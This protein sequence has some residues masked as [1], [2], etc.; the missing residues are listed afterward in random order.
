LT[1][2]RLP[3]FVSSRR[4][5]ALFSSAVAVKV[6]I[7]TLTPMSLE[8]SL[9]LSGSNRPYLNY[10]IYTHESRWG[11][12]PYGKLIQLL[13]AAWQAMPLQHPALSSAWSVNFFQPSPA[14]YL[15][16][17]LLKLP[18]LL[19]DIVAGVLV[20]RLLLAEGLSRNRASFGFFLWFLNPYVLLVNEMWAA[21]DLISVVLVLLTLLFLRTR[22][23]ILGAAA[24][25]LA[26]AAKLFPIL[27]APL[28]PC[29]NRGRKLNLLLGGATILGLV[30]YLI[31]VS[32]ARYDVVLQLRQH[33]PFTQ[34][35][36]DFSVGAT[37]GVPAD[38]AILALVLTYGFLAE[39]WPKGRRRLYEPALI[40]MLVYFA[41][42]NWFPQLLIWIIPFLTLDAVAGRR[43][44]AYML[45][46]L[47]SAFFVEAV[48]FAAY[49]TSYGNAFFFIPAQ[50]MP[51]TGALMA[52]LSF[53]EN[54]LVL[55]FAVPAIRTIF[56]VTC[57]I[58]SLSL[59]EKR[60]GIL[61]S[62]RRL[63]SPEA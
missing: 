59:A 5:L 43:S 45:T 17:F 51:L 9:I 3:S 49:F 18:F 54:D 25:A 48:A 8:L 2:M 16:V 7:M 53:A 47:S 63:T 30:G 57:L 44:L 29:V 24:F 20:Y 40:V 39:K 13:T 31:W 50:T 11:M 12:T 19:L 23:T 41:L 46:L 62:I 34:N 4:A 32:Y 56:S 55:S 28:F 22:K 26:I 42:S 37:I 21:V 33:D 60:T 15:L 38:L 58:Y 35:F 52:Y 27:F 6:V 61:T 36:D 10:A 14:L 1:T